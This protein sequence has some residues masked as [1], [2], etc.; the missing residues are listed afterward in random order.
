[1]R[2][3]C[4]IGIGLVLGFSG[5]TPVRPQGKDKEGMPTIQITW[6]GQSFFEIKSSKGT[7]I[8]IDPHQIDAYGRITIAKADIMYASHFH[9]DHTR[10]TVLEDLEKALKDKTVQ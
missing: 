8:V 1:M 7:N 2:R 6:H 4:V 5:V 10:F 3:V 9:D